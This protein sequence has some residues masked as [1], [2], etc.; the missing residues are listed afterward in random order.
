[1]PICLL[2]FY[3]FGPFSLRMKSQVRINYAVK[4]VAS[5]FVSQ[6][7]I[8][9]KRW[10]HKFILLFRHFCF[11]FLLL[12]LLNTM[13][14]SFA[15]QYL[16]TWYTLRSTL[17]THYRHIATNLHQRFEIVNFLFCFHFSLLH[18]MTMCWCWI[19]LHLMYAS[20]NINYN[21]NNNNT[22]LWLE[23]MEIN[24]QARTW[25]ANAYW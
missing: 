13:I 22:W 18:S 25:F 14:H 23:M 5:V 21:H 6:T 16:R 4:F 2:I 8:D 19:L 24:V 17:Y 11:P 10:N 3:S 20:P 1:M 7:L 12:S 15:M 9:Q